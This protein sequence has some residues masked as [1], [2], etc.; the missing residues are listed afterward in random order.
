MSDHHT[1]GASQKKLTHEV[2]DQLGICGCGQPEEMQAW[3]IQLLSDLERVE[4]KPWVNI[5]QDYFGGETA[6]ANSFVVMQAV[7]S[8]LDA[9]GLLEHGSNISGS[10]LTDK[11][12]LFLDGLMSL[13]LDEI[14]EITQDENGVWS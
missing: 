14:T 6:F 11:G 10:W 13:D 7:L 12:K 5:H 8:W 9:A 1:I 2:W 4:G 3:L